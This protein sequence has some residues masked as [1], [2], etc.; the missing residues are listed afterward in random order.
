MKTFCSIQYECLFLNLLISIVMDIL[1]LEVNTMY[2]YIKQLSGIMK[3]ILT[4]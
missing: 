4:F 1:A 2:V 3:T